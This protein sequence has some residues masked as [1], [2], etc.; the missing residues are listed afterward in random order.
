MWY[1]SFKCM[2]YTC[3][4]GTDLWTNNRTVFIHGPVFLYQKSC[5][6][7][8]CSLVV[9]RLVSVI[10]PPPSAGKAVMPW[11]SA[12][13]NSPV[14]HRMRIHQTEETKKT[15]QIIRT[16]FYMHDVSMLNT[17]QDPLSSPAVVCHNQGSKVKWNR[18]LFLLVA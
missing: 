12:F 14:D 17:N 2:L 8:L 16:S 18:G 5:S 1:S 6:S 15:F 11:S 9:Q 3:L 7:S 13:K 10:L 4:M